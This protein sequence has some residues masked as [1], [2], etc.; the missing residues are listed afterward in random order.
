MYPAAQPLSLGMCWESTRGHTYTYNHTHNLL[1]L[2]YT[3]G[4]QILALGL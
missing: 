3:S 4:Q 2:L 1:Y